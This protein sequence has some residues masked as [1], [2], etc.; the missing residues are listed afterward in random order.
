[1]CKLIISL[2]AAP[3]RLRYYVFILF[4][5]NE[6][7]SRNDVCV[8]ALAEYFRTSESAVGRP[9]RLLQLPVRI[10]G[11]VIVLIF[12]LILALA[13]LLLCLLNVSIENY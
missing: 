11:P 8:Y 4:Q 5:M 13:W 6:I 3:L 7:T 12:V 9:G 2:S 1:M 10:P